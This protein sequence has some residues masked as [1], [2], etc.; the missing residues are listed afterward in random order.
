M[1]FLN[2]PRARLQTSSLDMWR[3]REL[4]VWS[5]WREFLAADRASRRGAFAAYST[6]LDAEAAAASELAHAHPAFAEAG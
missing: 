3:D 6:A 1:T 2:R 4:L 5:R